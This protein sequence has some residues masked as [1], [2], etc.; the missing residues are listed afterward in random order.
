MVHVTSLAEAI[1]HASGADLLLF[2]LSR[3]VTLNHLAEFRTHSQAIPVVV[4]AS[5]DDTVVALKAVRQGAQE[6]LLKGQTSSTLLTRTIRYALERKRAEEA[7]RYRLEFEKLIATISTHFINTSLDQLDRGINRALQAIGEFAGVDRSYLF[8]FQGRNDAVTSYEWCREGIDSQR[9]RR[10]VLSDRE[11]HWSFQKL[12]QA[13]TIRVDRVSDLPPEAAAERHELEV[14]EI[15][16]LICIPLIYEGQVVGCLGF[17]SVR[18]GKDWSE[19]IISLLKFAGDMFVNALQRKQAESEIQRVRELLALYSR[20]TNEV[21]WDWN[22]QT[23]EVWW[24]DNLQRIYGHPPKVVNY[25]WWVDQIHPEDRDPILVKVKQML[26]SGETF[27]V[28]EYRFRCADGTYASVLDR[29]YVVLDENKKAVRWVGAL[30]NLSRDRAAAEDLTTKT[31]ST[32][33]QAFEA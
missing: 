4:L 22:L 14:A 29:G 17:E 21:L 13:E 12:R 6:Y 24:N 25:Q 28:L 31:S 26:E 27:S 5:L 1:S 7:M 2:S 10:H 3:N 23:D 20:V 11:F 16:S 33:P 9:E 32:P 18:S 19:D 15:Q 8:Q 30:M